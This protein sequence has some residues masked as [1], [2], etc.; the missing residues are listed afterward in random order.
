[1]SMH[2]AFPERLSEKLRPRTLD[3]FVGLDRPKAIMESFVARP[4]PDAFYF[5]GPSGTGKT[6][7]ALAIVEKLNAEL[8]HIPSRNCDLE[9]IEDT[10]RT[11]HRSAYN[12]FGPNAGQ[13][14]DFH[15]ILVDEADQM[16]AAAQLALLSK[17]DSTAFPPQTIFIFTANGKLL[18]EPRF[19]SRCRVIEFTAPNGELSKYL[20]KVYKREGGKNPPDFEKIATDADHNVRTAL[21]MLEDELAIDAKR[22]SLPV[23]AD[24][25]CADHT[26]KCGECQVV[27]DCFDTECRKG[28]VAKVCPMSGRP[29][30]A[31]TTPERAERARKAAQTKRE[32]AAGKR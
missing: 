1:M 31:G 4:R 14:C 12:F 25:P 21:A 7:M 5:I 28:A 32:K 9:T 8:H 24:K 16:T 2:F 15:V 18:L 13:P 10:I 22:A 11:C 20:A 26:H 23:L 3:D 29:P 19:L 27:I 6:T 30:C 17:L